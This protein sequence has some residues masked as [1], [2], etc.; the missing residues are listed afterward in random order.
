[1]SGAKSV[2]YSVELAMPDKKWREVAVVH[3]TASDFRQVSQYLDVKDEHGNSV[4]TLTWKS[5]VRLRQVGT[6]TVHD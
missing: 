5:T 6:V 1:M 3:V 2:T 4:L